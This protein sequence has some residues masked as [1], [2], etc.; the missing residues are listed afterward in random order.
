MIVRLHRLR[1]RGWPVPKYQFAF[2]APLP[3]ELILFELR[4]DILNRHTRVARLL[5][6]AGALRSDIPDLL[7][8]Q[9]LSL[10]RERMVLSGIERDEDVALNRIVD[11]AQ[12]WVCWLVQP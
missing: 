10:T 5:T 12:T 7:D 11:F 2:R 6:E 1:E 8:A 9:V 4:D 3:G